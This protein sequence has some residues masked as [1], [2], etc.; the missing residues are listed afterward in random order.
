MN[1]FPATREP[2]LTYN[3]GGDA[4]VAKVSDFTPPATLTLAPAADTNPVGTQH[5]VTATVE[6]ALRNPV[7]NV[8]VRFTVAGSVRSRREDV[9]GGA[10]DTDAE[11]TGGH[12]PGGFAALRHCDG[13]PYI[14]KSGAS[15]DRAISATR[16]TGR[17]SP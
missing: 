2:D 10:R 4:F 6:D 15:R 9:G 14:R 16:T 17:Y 5:C 7:P 1:A 11:P 3:G 8:T 12:K 13:D